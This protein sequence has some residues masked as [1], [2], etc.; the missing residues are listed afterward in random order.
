MT[1]YGASISAWTKAE[2]A[3]HSGVFNYTGRDLG[4]YYGINTF[5]C[6][7]YFRNVSGHV[8]NWSCKPLAQYDSFGLDHFDIIIKKLLYVALVRNLGKT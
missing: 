8:A 1:T 2:I 7:A 6:V 3:R 4:G 5:L